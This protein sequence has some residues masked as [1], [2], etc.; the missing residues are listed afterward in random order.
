MNPRPPCRR[1][2]VTVIELLVALAAG[3]VVLAAAWSLFFSTALSGKKTQALSAAVQSGA[4]IVAA[5]ND[6]WANIVPQPLPGTVVSFT[7]PDPDLAS[8]RL[9]RRKKES[10][11]IF[12]DDQYID[13]HVIEVEYRAQRDAKT[14]LFEIVRI[15]GG[16]ESTA[17][18]FGGA[19]ARDVRFSRFV[20]SASGMQFVRIAVILVG[21][22]DGEGRDRSRGT[23]FTTLLPIP[24]RPNDPA[25]M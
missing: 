18:R 14:R 6:D 8:F 1:H 15:E 22:N 10:V 19:L 23:L 24:R 25:E 2:G 4:M 17:V 16:D 20:P 9:S 13:D 3:L 7:P 11:G 12:R 21:E 5:I